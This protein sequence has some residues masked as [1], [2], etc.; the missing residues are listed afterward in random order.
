MYRILAAA[1]FAL[2]AFAGIASAQSCP[3]IRF[4]R[5]A[6]SGEVS[7][8]VSEGAPL[9]F[10]FGSGAGQTARIQLF[11]SRNTCFGVEGIQD[12]QDDFSFRTQSR[13]YHINVHQLFRGPGYENFVLRLTIR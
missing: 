13:S 10:T 6:S 11:G 1:F 8:A 12:C 2:V 7:G 4:A 9:C 3:E 5:G